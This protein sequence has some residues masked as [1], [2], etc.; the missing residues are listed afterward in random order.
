M[1]NLL[2]EFPEEP[3]VGGSSN[4]AG[5]LHPASAGSEVGAVDVT[6]AKEIGAL[7]LQL[8][9][10]A[11]AKMAAKVLIPGKELPESLSQECTRARS[12]LQADSQVNAPPTLAAES[13]LSHYRS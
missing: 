2:K 6:A 11:Q 9:T 1:V 3:F 5:S 7:C 13:G 8:V 4:G 10:R 12:V